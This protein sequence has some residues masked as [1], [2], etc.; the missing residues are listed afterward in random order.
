[1]LSDDGDGAVELVGT[2]R[3]LRAPEGEERDDDGRKLLACSAQQVASLGQRVERVENGLEEGLAKV[4][5][6]ASKI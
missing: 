6:N 4:R 5:V 2:A 1:M 3:N